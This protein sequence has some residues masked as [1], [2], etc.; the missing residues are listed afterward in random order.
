MNVDDA[1]A[2]SYG[3]GEPD[4]GTERVESIDECAACGV[5]G[6]EGVV[7]VRDETV[8]VECSPCHDARLLAAA[9][10]LT[11][12]QAE[13]YAY[14]DVHGVARKATAERLGI[15][16]NVVDQHLAASRS[17]VENARAT[18]EALHDLDAPTPALATLE[19]DE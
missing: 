9:G 12:R 19:A 15:S 11:N 6:V 17:K 2:G 7:N 3:D 18:V 1:A 5:Q 4:T 10:L 16:P 8:R 13:V 14:R